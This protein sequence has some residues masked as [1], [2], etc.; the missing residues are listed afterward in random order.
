MNTNSR[1]DK[2]TMAT[3]YRTYLGTL[4]TVQYKQSCTDMDNK[5]L[6]SLRQ[7]NNVTLI[8]S[9]ASTKIMICVTWGSEYSYGLSSS[10][11]LISCHGREQGKV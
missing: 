11:V 3:I 1:Q 10:Y 7:T 2:Y 6:I 9:L 5:L 4:F 8:P